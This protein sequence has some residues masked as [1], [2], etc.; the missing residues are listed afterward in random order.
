[1]RTHHVEY[2]QPGFAGERLAVLTWIANIRRA[3]A[4]RCYQFVRLE[5]GATLAKGE[6][7]CVFTDADSGKPRSIPSE[8]IEAVSTES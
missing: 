1:M 5:D 6:T 2:L 3:T 8:V 7:D 4:L